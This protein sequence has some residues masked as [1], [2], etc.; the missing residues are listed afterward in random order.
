MTL[1]LYDEDSVIDIAEAIRTKNGESTQYKIADM[2][3]AILDIPSGGGSSVLAAFIQ[4]T[5]SGDFVNEDVTTVGHDA[6][7]GCTSLS[8]ISLPNCVTVE[9]RGLNG[10]S[11]SAIYIPKVKD[12]I[13]NGCFAYNTNLLRIALPSLTKNVGQ[14]CLQGCSK[15]Q[16]CDLG[17]TTPG[18][19]QTVFSG[20]SVLSTLVLRRASVTAL[21]HTNVFTN[22]PF[23]SDKSGGTLYVP[24]ALISDYQNA[25][26]WSI[27]LGYANNHILPIEGSIYE[28]QYA[29]GTPIE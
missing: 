21:S 5:I 22:T 16:A 24:Q 6:F 18:L 15:L 12:V 10:T 11:A 19:N 26:N 29:D 27:I 17:A 4:R 8:S 3:Q 20:C 13:A 14:N 1:K 28:T 23:A 25:T 7:N 2:A 9:I